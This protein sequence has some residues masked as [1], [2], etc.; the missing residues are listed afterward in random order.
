MVGSSSVTAVEGE[1]VTLT[2]RVMSTP[3][4]VVTW[5]FNGTNVNI[6]SGS[7]RMIQTTDGDHSLIIKNATTANTG[8]Y[9]CQV[10]NTAIPEVVTEQIS[11]AVNCEWIVIPFCI[12]CTDG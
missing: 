11:L 7:Y 2:C 12:P 4:P 9:T 5:M 3:Q 6:S 8:I 10:N 1:E